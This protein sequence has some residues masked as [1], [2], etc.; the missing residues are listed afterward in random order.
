LVFSVEGSGL[1]CI[2]GLLVRVEF[3]VQVLRVR[4]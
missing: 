3:R 2:M 4:V 1:M